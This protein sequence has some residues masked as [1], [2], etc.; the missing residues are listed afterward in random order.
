MAFDWQ[1]EQASP[2]NKIV[3]N[4][5]IAAMAPPP[6]PAHIISFAQALTASSTTISSNDNLPQPLIRGKSVSI[7]ISEDIYEKGMAV[8][9]RNLR[10][11]LVM[12]KG[13]KPYTTKDIHTKLQNQWKTTGAWSM[14]PLGR[15]FYELFFASEDDMCMIWAKGTVNLKPS[16]LRL[17][18]WTKDFNKHKQ[19]NTHA[20]V[21]I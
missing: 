16:V 2:V 9:K 18:E 5:S 14:T 6:K 17:F 3:M 1:A 13:K 12:N 8:C 4:N 20:Q 21:W 7:H 11:R 10:G 19:R 15:G